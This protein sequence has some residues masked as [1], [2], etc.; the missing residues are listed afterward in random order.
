MSSKI[1]EGE[2]QKKWRLKPNWQ[3]YDGFDRLIETEFLTPE[4]QWDFVDL[5]ITNLAYH[6]GQN[7]R[8]YRRVWQD[9]GINFADITDRNALS[10]LPILTKQDVQENAR[11]LI[12]QQLPDGHQ[13]HTSTTTSG[14]TGEPLQIL[15]SRACSHFF[16]L[17]KQRQL[18][19]FRYDPTGLYGS[20]R[21][22]N[23]LP[24]DKNGELQAKDKIHQ[25]NAWPV[26]GGIFETGKFIGLDDA[27]EAEIK[28]QWLEQHQPDYLLGQSAQIEHI[29][30][31][32][33]DSSVQ[34]NLK[35]IEAISQQL[36]PD[37]QGVIESS[38]GAPVHQNYGL[39]E[40]GIVA[41][42]CPEGG[43][44]HVH[45]EHCMIEIVDEQGQPCEPGQQGRLLVTVFGNLAMPLIR[46]DTD[47]LAIASTEPCICGRTLP[48]FSGIQGRYRRTALLPEGAWEYWVNFQRCL[49][50]LP[51]EYLHNLRQY[52]LFHHKN[53]DF[54]LK[55]VTQGQL[56]PKLI[57][58]VTRLWDRPH[59]PG[60]PEL[61][62]EYVDH[63]HRPD[64]GKFQNFA[65]EY[66][67]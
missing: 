13:I 22:A 65:S 30:L 21:P 44:Y 36:T 45:S 34:L 28:L 46:Y 49:G 60:A 57:E 50:R 37:M 48:H 56:N 6:C 17:L 11:Q 15:Y 42:R 7:V 33:R 38:M 55:L 40:V 51:T 10:R 61:S 2:Q 26:V 18:R 32:A 62:I 54:T 52:Q 27:N 25:G 67:K 59:T 31:L 66:F 39:N 12:S 43:Q 63:I 41:A 5:Q 1:E 24:R 9:L 19:W 53:L 64:G 20:L 16:T 4:E 23:D 47:D 14:T 35:G 29:A 58:E 8:Y 3:G